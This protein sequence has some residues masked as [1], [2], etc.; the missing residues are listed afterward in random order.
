MDRFELFFMNPKVLEIQRLEG[1]GTLPSMNSSMNAEL[2]ES[3]S[4]LGSF[5]FTSKNS[6]PAG[7]QMLRF[8][9]AV[10]TE[11]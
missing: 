5:S 6:V 9:M 2:Q 3:D 1:V 7:G 10:K 11:D 4:S 8:F